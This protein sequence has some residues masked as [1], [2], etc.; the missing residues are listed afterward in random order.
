MPFTLAHPAIVLPIVKSKRISTTALVIGTVIPDFKFYLQLKENSL[1]EDHGLGMLWVD[2]LLVLLFSYLF[3]YLLKKPFVSNLP[4]QWSEKINRSIHF[5]W[6]IYAKNNTWTVLLSAL[7][8]VSSHIFW[9]GFTHH[10]GY[11]V[12]M[13]PLLN[14]YFSVLGHPVKIFFLL[15]IAF[16]LLGLAILAIYI[17]RNN[18]IIGLTKPN[19][20][21]IRF[22]SSVVGLYI[23][24]LTI[25][26]LLFSQY[27]SFW[28]VVIAFIGCALYSWIF[29]S[30]IDTY[31]KIQY[32]RSKQ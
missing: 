7:L 13:I 11:F 29:I 25:R 23:L 22:W 4:I 12:R 21:M 9:D 28:S 26:L 32:V 6:R 8:G 24:L 14:T 31:K 15:Q 10:D 20:A 27:N 1:T 16:S 18:I 19:K 2:I 17:Y 5:D 3:H 30:I